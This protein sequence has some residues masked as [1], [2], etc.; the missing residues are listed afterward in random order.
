[1]DWSNESLPLISVAGTYILKLG[2]VQ[3]TTAIPESVIATVW[4]GASLVTI[5]LAGSVSSTDIQVQA[6]TEST[7]QVHPQ[8]IVTLVAQFHASSVTVTQTHTKL[9]LDSCGSDVPSSWIMCHPPVPHHPLLGF[10]I[11]VTIVY[12]LR[13]KHFL[14]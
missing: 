12:I 1:V 2:Y 13:T 6:T 8:L 5:G 14:S 10:D 7:V 4:S 11:I 9:S 3:V